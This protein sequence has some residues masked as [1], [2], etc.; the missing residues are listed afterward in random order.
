MKELLAEKQRRDRRRGIWRLCGVCVAGLCLVCA[1]M[2]AAGR[3]ADLRGQVNRLSGQI[4]QIQGDMNASID[5]I[6]SEIQSSLEQQTSIVAGWDFSYGTYDPKAQT[7]TAFA[8]ATP[9]TWVEGQTA[10][11]LFVLDGQP[12]T[13]DGQWKD[14]LFSAQATLPMADVLSMSVRFSAGGTTQTQQLLEGEAPRERFTLRAE[15]HAPWLGASWSSGQ[16]TVTYR[17]EEEAV[18]AYFYLP[19]QNGQTLDWPVDGVLRL[20]LVAEDGRKLELDRQNVTFWGSDGPGPLE[21]AMEY[22]FEVKLE[23]KSYAVNLEEAFGISPMDSWPEAVYELDY[24]D[25]YGRTETVSAQ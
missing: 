20:M 13:V 15:L 11:F 22:S 2:Y 18:D 10:Q 5:H 19:V 25:A 21:S 3:I 16:P 1:G 24:T 4:A 17:Q 7:V 8:R 9:K 6:R 14:G 12:M 23:K